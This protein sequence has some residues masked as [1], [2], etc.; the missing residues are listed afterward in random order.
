MFIAKWF[1]RVSLLGTAYYEEINAFVYDQTN[2][3]GVL[4]CMCGNGAFMGFFLVCNAEV[5]FNGKAN[6]HQNFCWGR[7]T[8]F[9]DFRYG[10]CPWLCCK[11]NALYSLYAF[12]LIIMFLYILPQNSCKL[13]LS[14]AYLH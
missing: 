9:I 13:V 10:C 4:K 5:D 6:Q 11:I 7:S 1:D 2:H 12:S 14:L 8:Q 3:T